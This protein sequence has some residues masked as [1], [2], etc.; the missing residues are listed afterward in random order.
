MSSTSGRPRGS[1]PTI[2]RLPAHHRPVIDAALSSGERL[3]VGDARGTDTMAQDYLWGKTS[4]IVVYPMFTSPRN[5]P[6]FS[7]VGGFPSD[8]ARDT[9]MTADPHRDTTW[10]RPGRE[11]SGT[12]KNLSRRRQQGAVSNT[13]DGHQD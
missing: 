11:R 2:T 6:G 8:E 3:A 7:T 10:V 1:A 13:P 4:A 12:Q 5:N 9:R